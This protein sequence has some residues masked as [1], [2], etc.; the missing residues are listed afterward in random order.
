MQ[1]LAHTPGPFV[2][3]AAVA[4][5]TQFMGLAPFLRMSIA[6][7]DF[8]AMAVQM[9][10]QA[11]TDTDD[12]ELWMN[13]STA[14]LSLHHQQPGLD[15]Q[16]Q[17]LGMKRVFRI[18]AAQQP[19][20]LRV[21]LLMVPGV[22]SANVPLDCLLENSDIDLLYYYVGADTL[23]SAPIPE[24]DVLMVGISANDETR[25]ALAQLETAL[26]DW[27]RP[28]IN[29]PHCVPRSERH[30][31]SL[32][33]QDI[34]GL[35]MCPVKRLSRAVLQAIAVGQLVLGEVVA[36]AS[37]PI[38][39]RP[40][41]SHG[42]LGLE[43]IE[44][45]EA[46]VGYL[47]NVQAEE[48]FQSRFV[49]YSK[50]DGLFRKARIFLI[51]G[52][53]YAC[54]MATSEHWMIHYVNAN[55]YENAQHRAEEAIY[56]NEFADFASRHHAALTAITERTQLE[57]V[58]IDCAETQDG[59]LLVFEIDPAMVIHAMDSEEVFPNKQ[60]H[61]LKVKNALRDLF[62]QR[63]ARSSHAQPLDLE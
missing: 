41:G 25:G 15:I 51:G 50:A 47:A 55:M 28:V 11:Q 34:P 26:A 18:P 63:A 5:A 3:D 43:K 37:Y 61:M 4:P 14:M 1:Q 31:A 54:H 58:G 2:A 59:K 56:L 57:Y 9:L 13:L 44:S 24:H 27:P 40:V 52:K 19:A 38:I 32:L 39:L 17:A 35:V 10:T 16:A 20:R 60:F 30:A 36:G 29:L 53:A 23:F 6:G 48:Y 22:L 42:G 46:I 33:L 7:V 12:A 49:D 21:L 8:T 45:A 62:L